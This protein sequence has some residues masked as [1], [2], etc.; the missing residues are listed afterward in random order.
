[1]SE[2]TKQII[3]KLRKAGVQSNVIAKAFGIPRQRVAAYV[4]WHTMRSR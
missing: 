1:M 3:V 4:A 2:A